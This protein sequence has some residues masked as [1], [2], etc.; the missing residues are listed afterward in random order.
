MKKVFLALVVALAM[1]TV[2]KA[3]NKVVINKTDLPKVV[4]DK[5]AADYSGYDVQ[6][7]FKI[8]TDKKETNY[9]LIVMKGTDKERLDYKA[10]GTFVKKEAVQ[11]KTQTQKT[12]T[13]TTQKKPASK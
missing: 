3:E 11:Q 8:T 1:A 13:Q 9:E 5:V 6:K 10:D 2:V 12:T 7:V 4:A